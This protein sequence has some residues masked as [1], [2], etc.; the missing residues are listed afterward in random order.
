MT[1]EELIVCSVAI[2]VVPTRTSTHG[3][4]A[5]AAAHG[6]PS[7]FANEHVGTVITKDLVWTAP[8]DD[9]VVT[10]TAGE[11]LEDGVSE[12]RP[13]SRRPATDQIVTATA[14]DVVG[15]GPADDDISTGGPDQPVVPVGADDR[16]RHA[17]A[18]GRDGQG[19]G[20]CAAGLAGRG[21]SQD[22]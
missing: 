7:R 2:Q 11:E 22:E 20:W 12:E 6:I 18:G 21:R 14:E 13:R 4:Q 16:G 1:S 5:V 17:A 9:G 8:S 10:G 19:L 15:T 3:V